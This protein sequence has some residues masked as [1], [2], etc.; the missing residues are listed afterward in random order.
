[1][2]RIAEAQRAAWLRLRAELRR[3]LRGACDQSTRT[4]L[5]A[6]DAL[7]YSA[8]SS[9]AASSTWL[10]SEEQLSCGSSGI[11][12]AILESSGLP[13]AAFEGF[14]RAVAT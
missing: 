13:A 7:P 1:M 12:R 9:H 5:A 10:P 2:P 11:R 14:S 3:L 4:V 6:F 8:S